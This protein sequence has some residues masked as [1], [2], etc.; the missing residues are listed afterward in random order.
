MKVYVVISRD[1]GLIG[2][3][4]NELLAIDV[5][6]DQIIDEEMGGGFPSVWI[7]PTN[8]ISQNH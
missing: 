6:K 5:C 7:V 8:V 1:R 2:V 3:Y 4:D